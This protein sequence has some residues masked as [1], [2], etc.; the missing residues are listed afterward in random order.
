MMP[1][2][3]FVV[4]ALMAAVFACTGLPPSALAQTRA[5][6]DDVQQFC[7]GIQ[8]GGGRIMQ[9]LK[10]HETELSASPAQSGLRADGLC[11]PGHEDAIS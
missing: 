9:C 8:P 7:P 4:V 10:A 11:H 6:A 2:R 3:R 1:S 5:C